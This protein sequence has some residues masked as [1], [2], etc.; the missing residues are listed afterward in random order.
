[1]ANSERRFK[2]LITI[3]DFLADNR[4]KNPQSMTLPMLYGF[5]CAVAS[6]PC[7]IFP[8]DWQLVA[9]G[10]APNFNSDQ[11]EAEIIATIGHLHNLVALEL[12]RS[13][14]IELYVWNDN[15]PSKPFVGF[16]NANNSVFTEFSSGYIKGYL[17]DPI[18]KK[19]AANRTDL[20]LSF[21]ISIIKLLE[22]QSTKAVN[23]LVS[24]DVMVT[25]LQLL[26]KSNYLSWIEI[27][28]FGIPATYNN[29]HPSEL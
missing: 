15:E 13:S 25:S 1:M 3:R 14:K 21:F 4:Y 23:D 28:K 12:S 5:L 11:Q 6:S 8:A 17:L 20:S 27:R 2:Q 24:D 19:L 9:L 7:F 18:L 29:Q 10:G 22:N 16:S 26:V